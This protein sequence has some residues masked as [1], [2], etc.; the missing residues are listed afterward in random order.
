MWEGG[1]T[2][3]GAAA[4]HTHWVQRRPLAHWPTGPPA[5]T[6]TLALW[7][8]RRVGLLGWTGGMLACTTAL[9]VGGCTGDATMRCIH[10]MLHAAAV[11]CRAAECP[12][13][14]PGGQPRITQHPPSPAPPPPPL[15]PPP[16]PPPPLPPPDPPR[17]MVSSPPPLATAG[18]LET[19]ARTEGRPADRAPCIALHVGV[20]PGR[21]SQAQSGRCITQ[22]AS[23]YL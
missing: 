16:P 19:P 18:L 22:Q 13:P 4:C 5:P 10:G 21:A 2:T 7:G 8:K 14:L 3:A 11:G 20:W 9:T 1:G 15:P 12:G 17:L 23:T 6:K